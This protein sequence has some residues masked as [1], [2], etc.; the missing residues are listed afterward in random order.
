MNI[1]IYM[2]TDVEV[3][4]EIP[5]FLYEQKCVFGFMYDN[6][7][8]T[9]FIMAEKGSPVI[10]GL[11]DLYEQGSVSQTCPNNNL[12]TEYL[13]KRYPNMYLTGI[14]QELES[15]VW[16]LPKEWFECPTITNGGYCVHHFFGTWLKSSILRSFF[17]RILK[18]L[19]F[20]IP[21][22]NFVHQT[23]G[24]R[25]T[26]KRNAFYERYLQDLKRLNK[27]HKK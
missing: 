12:F 16:I 7:V 5:S 2:D 11:L 20:H 24:R 23:I 18:T 22:I 19:D 17:R 14:E 25:R 13:V 6:L 15:G 3:K 8:S 4:K 9:A 10:K 1:G 21:L 27:T 26:I